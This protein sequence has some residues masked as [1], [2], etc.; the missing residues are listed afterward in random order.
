MS[1][2]AL[3]LPSRQELWRQNRQQLVLDMLGK[4]TRLSG[5]PVHLKLE[6]TN[7]CNL[8]CPMCPHDSMKRP[9]GY[10]EPALFR[11]IIDQ[12]VP[13]LEFAYVHHLG[14]SLFHGRIGELISYGQAAGVAMGLSTNATFLD[15]RKGRALLDSGLS[16]L[17]ISLDAASAESYDKMRPGGHFATTM[18]N[19]ERL[20]TL[21]Q[22][23]AH[24]LQVVVQMI[25]SSHNQHEV[26][27]FA[28]RWPELVVLKEARDWA[29]Q[30]SLTNLRPRARPDEP[31]QPFAEPWPQLAEPCRLPW[32][33]LTVLWDGKVVPCANVFEHT[34]LL[35]DLSRQ[36]LDEVWNG[37][38][39][40]A[41]RQAHLR[42]ELSDVPVCRT[43]P[44]HPLAA[45]D[46]VAV[47]QLSQRLR[48][49]A[50]GQ[51]SPRSG[52]S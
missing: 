34:N 1:E 47:D 39:L 41:L 33:E 27:A 15:D 31:R 5:R 3:R 26:E 37:L 8:S 48:N 30:V 44:R 22:A 4:Q 14:E 50:G 9:I 25:V 45:Q 43:C 38:P 51:L 16:F 7:F 28:Q 36:S 29:G 19:V 52:L 10:M 35:G 24:P 17:V 21:K 13:E 18:R 11:R 20:L 32:S 40:Q 49:Y 12:A 2:P 42:N 23:T 6:L 46:F